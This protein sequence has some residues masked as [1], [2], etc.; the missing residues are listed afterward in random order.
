MNSWTWAA[1]AV[2]A[3]GLLLLARSKQ[4]KPQAPTGRHRRGSSDALDTVVAWEPHATRILSNHE[5]MAYA[6]L[7]KAL[8]EYMVLAQVPLSRFLRV[9][10]RY[11]Y[12]EWLKRVGSL[13]ADLVVCDRS[14]EVVAVVEVRSQRESQRGQHRHERMQRVLRAARI[15]LLVWSEGDLPTPSSVRD[16]IVP[17]TA[18]DTPDAEAS[19]TQPLAG[20]RFGATPL[21]AVPIGE[22]EESGPGELDELHE[23]P[24]STW[25]DDFDTQPQPSSAHRR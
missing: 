25:F 20:L 5:R 4:R 3:I 17:K 9:P 11:S 19:R 12:A 7:V 14:S 24:P 13:S 22:A 21:S 15:K 8:P 2:L 10:T 18:A 23:P 1:L 6:V 16:M